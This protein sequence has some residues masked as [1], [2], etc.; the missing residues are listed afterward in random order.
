MLRD[1][2]NCHLKEMY[3]LENK[4]QMNPS[5]GTIEVNEQKQIT[6][7]L[8]SIIRNLLPRDLTVRVVT[9]RVM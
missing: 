2:E 1:G 7:I 3:N 4:L 5:Y 9:E 6:D 8:C